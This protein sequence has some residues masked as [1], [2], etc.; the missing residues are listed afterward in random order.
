MNNNEI[1][2]RS[3][4]DKGIRQLCAAVL[5]RALADKQIYIECGHIHNDCE[6]YLDK[7]LGGEM[8]KQMCD[9]IGIPHMTQL[10]IPHIAYAVKYSRPGNR[11]A[12]K[13]A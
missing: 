13:H 5:E 6:E 11:T 2:A 8:C 12:R 7:F 4:N 10:D 9:V 1:T 3:Y